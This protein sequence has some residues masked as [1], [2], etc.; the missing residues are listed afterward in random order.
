MKVSHADY[1][2]LDLWKDP[3]KSIYAIFSTNVALN[4]AIFS[5]T[6]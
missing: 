5:F 1:Y 4:V 3:L 2:Y 6:M